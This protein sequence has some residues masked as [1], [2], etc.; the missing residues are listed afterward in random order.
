[1]EEL[2]IGNLEWGHAVKQCAKK[3]F[4]T[5][6]LSQAKSL[7]QLNFQLRLLVSGSGC[8]HTGCA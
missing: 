5:Y 4:G 8:L 7:F 6:T 1:M 2:G 3:Q